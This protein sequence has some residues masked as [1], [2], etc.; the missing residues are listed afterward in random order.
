[1]RGLAALPVEVSLS[2]QSASDLASSQCLLNWLVLIRHQVYMLCNP[3][4]AMLCMCDTFVVTA[5]ACERGCKAA[6]L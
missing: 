2:K 5:S 3:Q 6:V 1:M 4:P